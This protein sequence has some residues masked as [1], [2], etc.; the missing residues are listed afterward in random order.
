MN[1]ANNLLHNFTILL[2]LMYFTRITLWIT[3]LKIPLLRIQL[4]YP[5]LKMLTKYY[6]PWLNICM[7][8]KMHERFIDH[9]KTRYNIPYDEH[10]VDHDAVVPPQMQ[11]TDEERA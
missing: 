6:M 2:V 3:L 7:I 5:Y 4:N 10:V 11:L 1:F 8:R 9:N